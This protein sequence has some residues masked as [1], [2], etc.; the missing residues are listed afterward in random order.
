MVGPE[1]EAAQ[2]LDGDNFSDPGYGGSVS[3]SLSFPTI[4]LALKVS[5]RG[6]KLTMVFTIDQKISF[7][8]IQPPLIIRMSMEGGTMLIWLTKVLYFSLLPH[9]DA[10]VEHCETGH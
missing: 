3:G 2:E 7:P 1:A 8:S 6:L 5:V 10:C 9:R 4:I